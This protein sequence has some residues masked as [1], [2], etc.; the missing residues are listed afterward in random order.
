MDAFVWLIVS[1][2]YLVV[3]IPVA[4][5]VLLAIRKLRRKVQKRKQSPPSENP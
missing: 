3:W 4:A 2:P 5:V 1:L